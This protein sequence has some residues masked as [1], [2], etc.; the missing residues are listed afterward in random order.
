MFGVQWDLVLAF[1]SKDTAKITST[2]VLTKDST[3]I[4]NYLN[5]TFDLNRGKYAQY[6]N[7]GNTWNNFDSALGSIVVSN[8]TTGKMKKTEQSSYENGILLT[9]GGTE[10]SK[11][12]NIY[13]IAGN[14]FEWTLE[15]TSDTRN[16]CVYRG[17]YCDLTGSDDPATGR[18]DDSTDSSYHSV[19]FRVS[20]F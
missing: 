7:A 2:D 1:M 18:D 13:D 17:G 6:I 19:G 12:M 20:L 10:Q 9:T 16:P 4:G 8:E 5:S 14:V 3:T 11:V 15:K